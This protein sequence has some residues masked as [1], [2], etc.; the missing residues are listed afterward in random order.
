[1]SWD[2]KY[3]RQPSDAH[4]CSRPSC[5]PDETAAPQQRSP[6]C[7]ENRGKQRGRPAGSRSRRRGG[8]RVGCTHLRRLLS[9]GGSGPAGAAGTGM[10]VS[11]W[12]R[13][14]EAPEDCP[15][16]GAELPRS[17]SC[18]SLPARFF[19]HPNLDH[20]GLRREGRAGSSCNPPRAHS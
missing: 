14:G 2:H 17:C 20:V 4:H 9:G 16:K 13:P 10:P 1:M 6:L 15:G 3:R 12:G 18:L 7:L 8:V 19:S 5:P 11:R